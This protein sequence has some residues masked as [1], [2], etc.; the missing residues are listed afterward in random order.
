MSFLPPPHSK[1]EIKPSNTNRTSTTTLADDP[2]LTFTLEAGQ[3]LIEGVLYFDATES[4]GVK[5]G[6]DVT[7]CTYHG[8]TYS[9]AI[10]Q[11]DDETSPSLGV[12]HALDASLG[13]LSFT[14]AGGTTG[15][16]S[17]IRLE[18]TGGV[19]DVPTSGVFTIQWAQQAST[20]ETL[21]LHRG[22]WIR[23]TRIE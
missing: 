3:W 20:T 21:A 23:A 17:R 14:G 22:S 1:F 7:D 4:T 16:D 6:V 9:V 18:L 2:D 11:E 15:L 8:I 12:E 19:V 5:I 13:Y 10:V